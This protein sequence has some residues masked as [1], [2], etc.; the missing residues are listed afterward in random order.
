MPYQRIS[1]EDKQRLVDAHG[2]GDDYVDLARQLGIKRTTAYAIIRRAQDNNGA[3]ARPRGGARVQ[4]QLVTEALIAAAIAVVEQHPDFTLDQINTELRAVLPQHAHIC[5]S[6]LSTMLNGQLLVMK[7]LEDA[8]QQRNSDRVKNERLIFAQWLM[9]YGMHHELIF[10][11]EAAINIWM[12][13]SRG[14]ARRGQRAV[15]VV[16]AVRG[17]NITV[18]F[19]I[20]ATN[21]MIHH[22][23]QQ[24]GM[25]A[26]RFNEYLVDVAAQLPNDGRHR[27]F[28]FDN[29]PAH[30]HAQQAGLPNNISLRYLPPYSPMLNVVEQCFSQWKAALK[31]DCADVRDQINRQEPAQRMATL[32]QLAIQNVGIITPANAQ[33]YFRLLQGHLPACMLLQDILM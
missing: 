11:D 10:I 12:K 28:I 31:R 18:K 24:G 4:R 17:Q 13:R 5:R 7:K 8:P 27:V 32:S 6:T 3:V 14:R 19:A 9:Q 2:R 22:D 29:A 21:G 33:A 26:L 20:S 15:R 1:A 23:L 16:G 30:A 25:N